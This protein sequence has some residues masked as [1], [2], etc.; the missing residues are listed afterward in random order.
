MENSKTTQAI[1]I[2]AGDVQVKAHLNDSPT[3][4]AIAEA[5]PIEGKAHRWGGEIY[6]PIHVRAELDENSRDVL[7]GGEIGYWPTGSALCIFFGPTPASEGTEIRAAS[8]VNVVGKVEGD[9]S[10]LWEVAG[11]AEVVVTAE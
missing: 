10:A 2:I 11:G 6:F 7:E 4:R 5:L 8:A 1:R 3:A 9:I